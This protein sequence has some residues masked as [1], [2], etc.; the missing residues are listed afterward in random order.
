MKTIRIENVPEL[1]YE[2]LVELKKQHG[3]KRWVDFLWI[4][5]KVM[6]KYES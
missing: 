5:E 6:D 2:R 4:V 3:V 1:L